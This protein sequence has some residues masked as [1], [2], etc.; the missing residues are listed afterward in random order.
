[1][2]STQIKIG[3]YTP[4]QTIGVGTF[5][6]VKCKPFNLVAVHSHTGHKVAMKI[7]NR[8][9]IAHLDMVVKVDLGHSV[10]ERNSVFETF[11]SPSHYQI[12]VQVD[13]DMKSSRPL[14]ISF[15]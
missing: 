11:A 14:R 5:G 2:A 7:V 10:K 13:L 1:M 12:V 15:W 4:L 6:K 8:R 3:N 9:K